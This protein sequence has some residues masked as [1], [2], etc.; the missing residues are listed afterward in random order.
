M[1]GMG[2]VGFRIVNYC[3]LPRRHAEART[4]S[5]EKVELGK[6]QFKYIY[7]YVYM[8]LHKFTFRE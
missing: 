3:R 8:T 1:N 7:I 6:A 4:L 5:E 2:T